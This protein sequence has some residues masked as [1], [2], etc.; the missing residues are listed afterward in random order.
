MSRRCSVHP[1]PRHPRLRLFLAALLAHRDLG[2]VEAPRPRRSACHALLCRLSLVAITVALTYAPAPSRAAPLPLAQ[3]RLALPAYTVPAGWAVASDSLLVYPLPTPLLQPTAPLADHPFTAF[4]D[5]LFAVDLRLQ[6]ARLLT[7][8]PRLLVS[9]PRGLAL[10]LWSVSGGWLIYTQSSPLSLGGPWALIARQVATG[11][12]VLLDTPAREGAPSVAPAA[13]S[14]G[15][16]VVWQSWTRVHGRETSVIRAYNLATGQ[17]HLLVQGGSVGS[18][19]Y[20]WPAVSGQRVVFARVL[21]AA[22]PLR[23]QMLLASLATGTVRPLTP[24]TNGLAAPAISGDLVVWLARQVQGAGQQV[25]LVNLRTGAH[26]LLDGSFM[27]APKAVA[28]RYALFP[29][30]NPGLLRLYDTWGGRTM[31]LAAPHGNEHPGNMVGAG[32]HTIVYGVGAY[33][34]TTTALPSYLVVARLP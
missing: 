18:W 5:R 33:S 4:R 10:S 16:T 28:G 19:F 7:S 14:D 11:R 34:S 23:A 20:A 24:L 13:S 12:A 25:A 26:E 31:T 21:A 27:E 8:R 1:A 15:H 17:R 29:T 30:G 6:G 32:E 3:A 22:P 9:G 2:G